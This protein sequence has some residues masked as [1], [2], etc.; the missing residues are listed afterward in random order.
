ME[1]KANYQSQ[2][3]EE[4]ESCRQA[5]MRTDRRIPDLGQYCA[6]T[7]NSVHENTNIYREHNLCVMYSS[8]K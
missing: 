6:P 4:T 2:K 8:N 3:T 7:Q 1:T 5:C